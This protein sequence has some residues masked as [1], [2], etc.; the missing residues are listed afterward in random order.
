MQS[1]AISF[2]IS[3]APVVF[4]SPKKLTGTD[5]GVRR[6]GRI[7]PMCVNLRAIVVSIRVGRIKS[8]IKEEQTAV[9]P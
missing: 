4:F 2:P 6:Q 8:G 7:G 3:L 1:T 9:E 5:H